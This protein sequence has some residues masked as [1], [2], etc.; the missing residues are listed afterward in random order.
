MDQFLVVQDF[1]R[2]PLIK[3]QS[4]RTFVFE[5]TCIHDLGTQFANGAALSIPDTVM[6]R[7]SGSIQSALA[8]AHSA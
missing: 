6:R 3:I 2:T 7:M 5:A 8:R 1:V 4:P